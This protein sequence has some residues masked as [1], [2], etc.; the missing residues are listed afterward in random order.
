MYDT[1]GHVIRAFVK[2]YLHFCVAVRVTLILLPLA[3]VIL[4]RRLENGPFR[5]GFARFC[6]DFVDFGNRVQKLF[7]SLVWKPLKG[8]DLAVGKFSV[9][10]GYARANL[11]RVSAFASVF[12][13]SVH[14][15]SV[16]LVG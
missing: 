9:N 5:S 12:P 7:F 15:S 10:V 4:L 14:R 13:A 2:H 6:D 3:S 8:F 11:N 1:L 16:W